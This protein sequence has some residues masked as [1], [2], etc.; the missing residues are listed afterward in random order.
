MSNIK[1]LEIQALEELKHYYLEGPSPVEPLQRYIQEKLLEA[2]DDPGQRMVVMMELI[3][4]N[5]YLERLPEFKE[6]KSYIGELE[7]EIEQKVIKDSA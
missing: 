6:F 1:N 5:L 3:R 7:K 2:G 4:F